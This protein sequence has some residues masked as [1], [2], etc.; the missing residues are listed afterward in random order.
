MNYIDMLAYKRTINSEVYILLPSHLWS[1]IWK[2]YSARR[3][4][5]F[6]IYLLIRILGFK[7]TDLCFC[8]TMIQVQKSVK[9]PSVL[10]AIYEGK[11]NHRCPSRAKPTY[12]LS[13][14]MN[15]GST[16]ALA[17]CSSSK[18]TL[19]LDHNKHSSCCEA[20]RA[21]HEMES[22]EF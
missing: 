4:P 22:S 5:S 8:K 16:P 2:N 19:T 15:P 1:K 6:Q 21:S 9:D 20:E 10:E 3:H 7:S 18:P 17:Y 13:H 14:S 11:H 12:R